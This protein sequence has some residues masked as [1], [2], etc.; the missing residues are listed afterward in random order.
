LLREGERVTVIKVVRCTV[1]MGGAKAVRGPKSASSRAARKSR[2][3]DF[4]TAA[5]KEGRGQRVVVEDC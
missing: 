1:I 4:M 3:L 2:G 5:L